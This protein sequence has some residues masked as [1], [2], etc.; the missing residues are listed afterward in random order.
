MDGRLYCN[1]DKEM[2]TAGIHNNMTEQKIKVLTSIWFYKVE[3]YKYLQII[4]PDIHGRFPNDTDYDYDQ[5]IM[6]QFHG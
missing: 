2:N 4:F 6:G 5:E 1:Y 3:D